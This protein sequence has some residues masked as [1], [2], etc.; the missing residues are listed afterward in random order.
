MPEKNLQVLL[1]ARPKTSVSESDFRIVETPLP[2][3]GDGQVMVKSLYLS[4]DPYMRGRMNDARSYAAK[5]EIGQVMTGEV[6]G[7]VVQSK[8]AKFKA[9]DS[10][11]GRVGWQ[12][13]ALSDGSDL[14][15][16]DPEA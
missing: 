11:A 14:R 8:N 10:V 1:A 15:K 2:A 16:I 5:V 13:Y 6:V 4:L 3:V 7:E 12:H 9:G